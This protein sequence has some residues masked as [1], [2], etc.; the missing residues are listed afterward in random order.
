MSQFG[1]LI[2]DL[3]P[4]QHNILMVSCLNRVVDEAPHL[5]PVLFTENPGLPT[6]IARFPIMGMIE[7]WGFRGKLIATDLETAFILK[8]LPCASEKFF[9]VWDLEWLFAPSSRYGLMHAAYYDSNTIVRSEHHEKLMTKCWKQP[10]A[11]LKDYDHNELI[12]IVTQ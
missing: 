9:Y 4:S 3:V 2:K 11:I 6:E 5:N 10:Y 7:A 1:V 12:K 8:K